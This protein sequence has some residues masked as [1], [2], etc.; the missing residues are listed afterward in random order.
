MLIEWNFRYWHNCPPSP[1]HAQLGQIFN[2]LHK[3]GKNRHK[4]MIFCDLDEY[5]YIP[6]EK[7]K[8][9][10]NKNNK[11]TY[12]FHNI[13]SKTLDGNIPKEFPKKILINENIYP[14]MER[15]KLIHKVDNINILSIHAVG[16]DATVPPRS[17]LGRHR[18][19]HLAEKSSIMNL[20][21]L[22]FYN[23]SRKKRIEKCNILINLEND[24]TFH[25]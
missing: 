19:H 10:I 13:W 20:K 22:H 12:V 16:S 15:S 21:L 14:Y 6:N 1:H 3:Y 11:N 4:Y 8:S 5:M 18:G 7:I 2:A 23:W 25:L 24:N 17:C 9:F